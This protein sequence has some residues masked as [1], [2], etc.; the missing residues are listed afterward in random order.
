[1]VRAMRATFCLGLVLA[2][3]VLFSAQKGA[4]EGQIKSL[5]ALLKSAV[6]EAEA[7]AYRVYLPFVGKVVRPVLFNE[8]FVAFNPAAWVDAS[9]LPW[10]SGRPQTIRQINV[11]GRT[12]IY[13]ETAE[14]PPYKRRGI[15]ST[16]SIAVT[17]EMAV[18]MAFKP[19]GDL[20]GMAEL[21][22]FDQTT[23]RYVWVSA[24]SG[25]SGRDKEL[26][27]EVSG[28]GTRK[29]PTPVFSWDE[30]LIFG[31]EATGGKTI[32]SLQDAKRN[33]KW[34]T[35]YDIPL[36][37]IFA[38]FNIAISQE[39]GIP[40]RGTWYMK[41]YIDYAKVTTAFAKS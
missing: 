16:S 32:I 20:D 41:S 21:W 34:S 28:Y 10:Y 18:E 7:A 2:T 25:N 27:T 13:M 17:S 36:S 39:L 35:T 37:S 12:A 30:W 33:T 22:L 9:Y 23:A 11:D 8:D 15:G 40:T 26:F 14:T 31:I 1:M 24:R 38:N 5:A 3:S 6:L 4:G 19:V 29:S